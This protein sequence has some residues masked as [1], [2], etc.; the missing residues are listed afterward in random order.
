MIY[1]TIIIPLLEYTINITILLVCIIYIYMY[2]YIYCY[3]W[4][5]CYY[6]INLPGWWFG[7]F[8]DF[9]I[10]WECHHPN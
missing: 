3:Y 4:L 6:T 1:N 7:S 8:F 5:D 10:Y 9:S 2:M